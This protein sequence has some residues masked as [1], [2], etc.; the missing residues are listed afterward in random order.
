MYCLQIFKALHIEMWVECF[1]LKSYIHISDS[2]FE[3]K[4][5]AKIMCIMSTC[6]FSW[7]AYILMIFLHFGNYQH[8]S[9]FSVIYIMVLCD[10]LTQHNFNKSQGNYLRHNF[11]TWVTRTV[12]KYLT[13]KSWKI[14]RLSFIILLN[15]ITCQFHTLCPTFFYQSYPF[16]KILLQSFKTSQFFIFGDMVNAE[17]IRV[18][19]HGILPS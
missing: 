8:L 11:L 13:L 12:D 19:S 18:L 1:D 16:L 7:W 5:I 9:F 2:I 14:S 17:T 15:I 10:L 4:I 3:F 6:L